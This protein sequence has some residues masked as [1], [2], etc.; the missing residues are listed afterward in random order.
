MKRSSRQT[1]FGFWQNWQ[2]NR[3][4]KKQQANSKPSVGAAENIRRVW[5]LGEKDAFV[6]EKTR[7]KLP[8]LAI[9]GIVLTL[10]FVLIFWLLPLVVQQYYRSGM[11]DVNVPQD[12]SD[13][14]KEKVGVIS[15]YVTNLMEAPQ[16]DS[17]RI[18]QVLFNEPVELLDENMINLLRD[19]G[20]IEKSSFVHVRTNEGIQGYIQ[21]SD[22]IWETASVEYHRYK[23]KLV[24]SDPYKNIR[25]HTS[26]GTLIMEVMMNTVLYSDF[27][28]DGVYKVALPGGETG[29]IGTSGLIELASTEG[30]SIEKV[31]VRYF[32]SNVQNFNYVTYLEHGLTR[33]GAS[34]EGVAYICAKV[35]GLEKMPRT[36]EEQAQFGEKVNYSLEPVT[37]ALDLKSILP[38]DLVFFRSPANQYSTKPV[39]MGI[40]IDTGLVLAVSSSRT[41]LRIIDLAE[42]PRLR[43]RVVEVRRIFT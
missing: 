43:S 23:Y 40:C 32:V 2:L 4:R 18:T 15:V 17:K 41:T 24:V 31:G 34:V 21:A 22:I 38:G 29:W 5:A 36:I 28:G 35:N 26:N 19:G 11:T 6:G 1:K 12:R 8:A 27:S 14:F 42:N 25:T 10:L 39:E 20:E 7:R 16:I 13:G 9:S 37:N 30:A 3:Q 33:D